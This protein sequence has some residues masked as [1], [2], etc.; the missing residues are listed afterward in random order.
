MTA[1]VKGK[2][3]GGSARLDEPMVHS[4]GRELW[5]PASYASHA[6]SCTGEEPKRSGRIDARDRGELVEIAPLPTAITDVERAYSL[7]IA[8]LKVKRDR[9]GECLEL[10][11]E[12]RP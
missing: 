5:T 8:D 11:E 6:R 7:V 4:C 12:M 9:V 1:A 10:L 2:G 3:R